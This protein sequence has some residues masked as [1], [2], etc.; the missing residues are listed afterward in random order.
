MVKRLSE[1]G[2][3]S[4]VFAGCA[5]LLSLGA[6]GGCARISEVETQARIL[7]EPSCTDFFFPI[8]FADR[9]DALSLPASALIASAGRH[10]HA[11]GCQVAQV[12][13]IGVADD[14]GPTDARH[15]LSRR[16]AHRV[17]E[18]LMAAG[19]PPAEFQESPLGE[20]A[21]APAPNAPLKRRAD[22]FIRFVR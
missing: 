21:P 22:V 14:D 8:Y 1:R 16:R 11:H 5:A 19:L 15:E 20:G 9:S 3:A 10:A 17:A 6:L 4:V 7:S 13:V 2:P 18:A 12:Q